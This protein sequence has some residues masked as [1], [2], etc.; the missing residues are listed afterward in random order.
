MKPVH[1]MTKECLM[2]YI[3]GEWVDPVAPK[4]LDVINPSTEEPIG[5]ISLGSA[6]DVDKAVAAARAAFDTFGR[7]SRD[8]RIALLERVI[9]TYSAGIK[10]AQ[11]ARGEA[12]IYLNTY[13]AAHDWD[14]C[15]G[16]LL[17]TEAGGKVTTLKGEELHYG[18][19]G[20]GQRGGLLASN[21]RLHDAALAVLKDM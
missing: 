19:A 13:D 6:A 7:T 9:E 3:N 2:F 10:L 21:G 20:A 17:V 11:V 15:A 14:I 5:R 12:D 8:E 16:H 1:E 4:T 18:R